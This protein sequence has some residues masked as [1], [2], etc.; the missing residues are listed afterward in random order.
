MVMGTIGLSLHYLDHPHISLHSP[1]ISTKMQIFT[2]VIRFIINTHR[3]AARY[4]IVAAIRGL[5][6]P[7]VGA[8]VANNHVH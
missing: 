3:A 5:E 2:T 6:E 1:N 8:L 7:P 4:V